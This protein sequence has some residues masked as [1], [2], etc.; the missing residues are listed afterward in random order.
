[1]VSSVEGEG[2]TFVLRIPLH[3]PA[4]GEAVGEGQADQEETA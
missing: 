2:S 1:M 4:A 3:D